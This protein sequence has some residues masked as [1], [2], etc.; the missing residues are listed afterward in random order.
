M[1]VNFLI[2]I[3]LGAVWGGAFSL[4]KYGLRTEG[5][6]TEMAARALI[7]FVA[8]F[9]LCLVLKKDLLGHAK[10]W[11]AYLVFAILGVVQLWLA[12][13][14]SLEFITAGLVSVMVAVTPLATFVITAL[15][16]KADRITFSNVAGLLIGV[17][18]LILVVG[19]D[20]ILADGTVLIGVLIII[21]GFI[22]FAVNGVLAP[23][24]VSGADPIVSATYFLGIGC[25]LLLMLSFIF[26]NPLQTPWN[27][28]NMLAEL[29]LG[30]IPTASGYVGF[31]YL[32]NKAGAFFA[33][34]VF[35]LVPVFGMLSGVIFLGDKTSL[36]QIVGIGVVLLGI[37]LIDREKLKK[38]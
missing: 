26:E 27:N 35:Y 20:N 16:L 21:G 23:R 30:I 9:I 13:A 4:I 38:V 33:S 36:M 18:G 15:I 2:L 31:Y 37:Y 22:L 24:M 32:I 29:A 14:Y 1:P 7:A 17:I 3:C 28:D 19:I 6:I 12:D 10:Y 25:V 5:P 34:T 11:F 8:L